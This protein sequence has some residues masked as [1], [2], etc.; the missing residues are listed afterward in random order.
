MRLQLSIS[1]SMPLL[2]YCYLSPCG[3]HDAVSL[4]RLSDFLLFCHFFSFELLP[5]FCHL[6]K[7]RR[8]RKITFKSILTGR[9]LI[10]MKI[11]IIL[12]I[13][14]MNLVRCV[15]RH[16]QPTGSDHWT[17]SVILSGYNDR[18]TASLMASAGP[19]S[20]GLPFITHS[21]YFKAPGLRWKL[22][23]ALRL[24][25]SHTCQVTLGSV[26]ATTFF[27]WV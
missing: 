18:M 4:I 13:S 8:R 3:L 16:E 14:S 1:E 5:V 9:A 25:H 24:S 10:L 17:V 15:S 22:N 23:Q 2:Y 21:P 7:K 12:W 6:Q 11:L 20:P 27:S 19:P 26:A